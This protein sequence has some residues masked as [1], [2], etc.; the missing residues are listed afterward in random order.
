MGDIDGITP[1]SRYP[2]SATIAQQT[3]LKALNKARIAVHLP[4]VNEIASL[5]KSAQSHA[6]F[7]TNHC[8]EYGNLGLSPH[9]ESKSYGDDFTG[10]W[11]WDRTAA[12]GYHGMGVGEVIAF[13]ADPN[14]A[15]DAWVNTLYHRLLI[16]DTGLLEVGYGKSIGRPTCPMPY[17]KTDVM[18]LGMGSSSASAPNWVFYPPDGA[19]DIP[20]AFDGYESPQPPVPKGGYPAGT[21]IT[22]QLKTDRV[23]WTAH[24]ITEVDTHWKVPHMAISNIPNKDAGVDNDPQAMSGMKPYLALYALD[25]LKPHTKYRVDI[26]MN[27]DGENLGLATTFTTGD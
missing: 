27:L 14:E 9:E 22:L 13:Y 7:V 5:N 20:R 24:K 10:Q 4:I 11:P 26:Q 25:P 21:M 19:H 16:F 2:R 12:A 6:D 8:V 17:K 18:D 15:V 23:Q 1:S 3:A